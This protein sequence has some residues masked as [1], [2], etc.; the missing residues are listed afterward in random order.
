[1]VSVPTHQRGRLSVEQ[2]G[3]TAYPENR[4]QLLV[5]MAS[6]ISTV[7]YCQK[8]KT[9]PQTP[10]PTARV[11]TSKVPTPH[12]SDCTPEILC[13]CLYVLYTGGANS[14]S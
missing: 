2:R 7:V 13:N 11:F 3:K 14:L 4:G 12:I 8:H 5:T 1:M 10:H 9:F 6:S